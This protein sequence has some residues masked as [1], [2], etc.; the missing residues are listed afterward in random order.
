MSA[1][2][3]VALVA[4]GVVLIAVVVS[5]YVSRKA[6][7][8]ASQAEFLRLES[9]ANVIR[10]EEEKKAAEKTDDEAWREFSSH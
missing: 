2:S 7:R 10:L 8:K 1:E 4:I 6:R 9:A 5:A 3:I